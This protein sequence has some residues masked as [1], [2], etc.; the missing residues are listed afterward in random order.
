MLEKWAAETGLPY[1]KL[2]DLYLLDCANRRKKLSMKWGRSTQTAMPQ[3]AGKTS[4]LSPSSQKIVQF[5]I[6]CVEM[7]VRPLGFH[8][9]IVQIHGRTFISESGAQCRTPYGFSRVLILT[10]FLPYS[11]PDASDGIPSGLK[12][13]VCG[14]SLVRI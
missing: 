4:R 12:R 14:G 8:Y 9:D 5:P 3:R 13:R 10:L 6:K 2:I 7:R 1:Q 11:S